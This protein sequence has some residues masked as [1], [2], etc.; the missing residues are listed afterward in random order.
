MTKLFKRL[1]KSKTKSSCRAKITGSDNII[2]PTLLSYPFCKIAIEGNSNR[3][4]AGKSIKLSGPL[5]IN[6]YGNNNNII[7][8]DDVS[9]QG[10][11]NI[12]IQ[13]HNPSSESTLSIG[14][15]TSINQANILILEPGSSVTIGEDCM[16]SWGI[17]LWASDTHSITDINGKLL[18]NDRH[19]IRIGNHVWVGA[20]VKIGKGVSIADHSVVGWGSIVNKEFSRPNVVIAGN[21][22]K[23]V[24]EGIDWNR[25]SPENYL[26]K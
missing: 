21:P 26:H 10:W 20:D 22:A 19:H 23:V 3:I 13:C 16:F 9:L 17:Y 4:I 5:N 14:S 2:D 24:K 1:F 12:G 6:I 11:I 15:H 7:L 25:L 18:N 8:G